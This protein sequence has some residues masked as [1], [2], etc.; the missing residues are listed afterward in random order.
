MT[1]PAT[2]HAD[3]L[4]AALPHGVAVHV[5]ATTRLDYNV[6]RALREQHWSIEQLAAEASRDLDN[7]VKIG[8]V[9]DERIAICATVPP[10]RPRS[11]TGLAKLHDGCCEDGWIY[12]ESVDP[13][14]TIKCPGTRRTEATA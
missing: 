9:V 8:A 4:I 10:A 7:A 11:R 1:R 3:A 2:P 6:D 13:P 5:R 14:R 12:D